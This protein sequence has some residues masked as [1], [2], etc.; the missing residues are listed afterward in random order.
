MARIWFSGLETGDFSECVG[1]S[2][3]SPSVQTSIINSGN[4][5]ALFPSSANSAKESLTVLNLSAAYTRAY[6]YVDGIVS[7]N[8]FILS[9]QDSTDTQI[10][11]LLLNNGNQLFILDSSFSTVGT[12]VQSLPTNAWNLV[13]FKTVIGAGTGSVEVK[14]NGEVWISV[15]S[16]TNN[17]AGNVDRLFFGNLCLDP[18]SGV[19][20]Y[21]DDISIDSAVYPGPGKIIARQGTAG[22]PTYN[23]WTKNGAAT[24]ALCWSDTPFNTATNCSDNV[25]SDKQT[26]LVWPFNTTQGYHGSETISSVDTINACKVAVIAKTAVAG[27]LDILRRYN[28]TDTTTT[29]SLTTSDAYY[30]SGIFTTTY[31]NI[32][33]AEIGGQNDLIATLVTIEDAWFM[34]DYT[35]TASTFTFDQISSFFSRKITTIAYM[36]LIIGM[37]PSV[38]Y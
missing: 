27:N 20:I 24:A 23:S 17:A 1:N 28:G 34:V 31:T 10:E 16:L 5:A 8:T 4:Y 32:N 6:I 19:N 3:G 25:L 36:L 7:N 30:D 2:L 21:I 18:S 13:E 26:M 12:S 35:P 22:T 15:G 37:L 33:A 14:V 29:V 11:A 38:A 9:H